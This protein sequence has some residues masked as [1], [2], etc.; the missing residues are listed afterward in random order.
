MPLAAKVRLLTLLT[1]LT[2]VLAV[3]NAPITLA[4]S[5]D[6][7]HIVVVPDKMQDLQNAL[8]ILTY[9]SN[10]PSTWTRV[11]VGGGGL[12]PFINIRMM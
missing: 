12:P 8:D 7:N 9:T 11:D 1:M 6:S 3:V 4:G 5:S 10:D 2:L